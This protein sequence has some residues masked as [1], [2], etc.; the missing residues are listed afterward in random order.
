MT[1]GAAV[2]VG[3]RGSSVAVLRNHAEIVLAR[4]NRA[5][6]WSAVLPASMPTA[7]MFPNDFAG[8][9]RPLPSRTSC[10]LID[11]SLPKRSLLVRSTASSSLLQN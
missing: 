11:P 6:P 9:S 5:R 10:G 2:L 4:A 3:A 7:A 1:Q 8:W